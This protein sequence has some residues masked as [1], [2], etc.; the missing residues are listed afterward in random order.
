MLDEG[1]DGWTMLRSTLHIKWIAISDVDFYVVQEVKNAVWSQGGHYT[2]QEALILEIWPSPYLSI[3]AT[4]L[5][6]SLTGLTNV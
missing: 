3:V 1:V 5:N 2:D 4:A 6:W